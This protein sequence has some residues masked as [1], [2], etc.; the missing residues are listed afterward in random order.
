[1]ARR[2]IQSASPPAALPP[3]GVEPQILATRLQD[4]RTRRGLTQQAA[5]EQLG[6]AR[7][8]IVAIEK[9]ERRLRPDDVIKLAEIYAVPVSELVRSRPQAERFAI[10][11]RSLLRREDEPD[12]ELLNAAD[13]FERLCEDYVA[14]E[15]YCQAPLQRREPAE[16][17]ALQGG[18]SGIPIDDAAEEIAMAERNRL[19]LGQGP[20]PNLRQLLE[21]EVG[22]RVFGMT[23]PSK[24][25]AMF[26]Y[27]DSW[28]GCIAVNRSHPRDRRRLSLAHEYAHFLTSRYRP[29]FTVLGRYQRQPASER[30]ANAFALSFLLPEAGLRARFHAIQR[31]KGGLG[32]VTPADLLTLA[33]YYGASVEALTLRLEDLRLLPPGTW[34]GLKSAGFKVR[35]AQDLLGITASQQLED[36]LPIRYLRLAVS[37]YRAEL[38]SE[39]QLSKFLRVGRVEARELV[40]RL[41]TQE[42]VMNDGARG[43]LSLDL[44]QAVGAA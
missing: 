17:D 6:V 12:Q 2:G 26:A 10:Q 7:T 41:E 9:G 33:D 3:A 39:G 22:M 8:T 36:V 29:E 1:M 34:E 43:D 13:D 23:L 37:A 14:L 15:A 4:A 28:G 44:A 19:G 35:E 38:I 20:I 11:F 31:A 40:Q 16:Y 30:L 5:A 25:A 21:N 18:E 42:I 32:A 27:T 24:L